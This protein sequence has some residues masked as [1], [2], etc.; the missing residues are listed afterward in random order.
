M[1]TTERYSL[2]ASAAHTKA[3]VEVVPV[4]SSHQVSDGM[5]LSGA[6]IA[7]LHNQ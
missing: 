3:H 7:V 1:V 2:L 5:R 6:V 4:M